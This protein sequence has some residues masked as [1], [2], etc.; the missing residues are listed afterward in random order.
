VARRFF[1]FT[2]S[3]TEDDM[4]PMRAIRLALGELLAADVP[5]LA[6]AAANKIALI[7]TPIAVS[8]NVVF[9][10]LH[11][12][13]F[14]GST[15]KSGINGAQQAGL[16]PLTGDQV[17]TILAPA[18]GWRWEATVAPSP[19]QTVYGFALVDD[20]LAVLW[21]LQL[22]LVPITI[23]TVGDFVDAGSVQMTFVLQ[24]LS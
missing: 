13:T 7:T 17:I 11:L 5:T 14:T 18:G 8:E 24:P 19:P 23:A 10:D 2:L 6:P 1:F 4:L 9:G 15:P 16:N 21:G 22:L 3:R 20:G 12:A